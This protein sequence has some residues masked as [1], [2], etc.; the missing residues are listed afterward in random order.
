MSNYNFY[1]PCRFR[2]QTSNFEFLYPLFKTYGNLN[3]GHWKQRELINKHFEQGVRNSKY[4]SFL[5][6]FRFEEAGCNIFHFKKEILEMLEHTDVSEIQLKNIKFPFNNFYI[7]LRELGKPLTIGHNNNTII[8]GVYIDFQPHTNN[9]YGWIMFN[10]CEYSEYD[11]DKDKEFKSDV[12]EKMELCSLNFASNDATIADAIELNNQILRDTF[13]NETATKEYKEREINSQL[14]AYKL[15]KDNLNLFVNCILYITSEKPD[16]TTEYGENLPNKLKEKLAKAD[17]DYKKIKVDKEL[18][19]QGFSKIKI[20]GNSFT[21]QINN[22]LQKTEI[23]PH[24]RRGHWRNQ[25]F[26]KELTETKIIWIQPTIINKEKGMP[27]KGH[28][29]LKE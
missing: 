17:K 25:P 11:K 23:A 27:N 8:D 19:K 6:Y 1:Y 14:E 18:I 24:W 28:I 2:E 29:Y 9:D 12:V 13:E 3:N 20:V 5:A 22:N 4:S 26:G 15:L 7:S 16:I 10:V 21:S